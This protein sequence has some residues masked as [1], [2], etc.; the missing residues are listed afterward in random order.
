MRLFGPL[1]P[2]LFLAISLGAIGEAVSEIRQAH[3]E[4]TYLNPNRPHIQ[5]GGT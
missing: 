2:A 1:L 3:S 4:P 5:G